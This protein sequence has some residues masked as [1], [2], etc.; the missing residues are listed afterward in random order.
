MCIFQLNAC[1]FT[2][3][4]FEKNQTIAEW[5]CKYGA[6]KEDGRMYFHTLFTKRMCFDPEDCEMMKMYHLLMT[7]E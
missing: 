6:N 3:Q 2:A 5:L 1:Y 7:E 4:D